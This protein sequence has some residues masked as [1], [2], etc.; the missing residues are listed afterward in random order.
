MFQGY[1]TIYYLLSGLVDMKTSSSLQE[2]EPGR[3]QRSQQEPEPGRHQRS[4]PPRRLSMEQ[5]R[6]TPRRLSTE[7]FSGSALCP[8]TVCRRSRKGVNVRKDI[9][10]LSCHTEKDKYGEIFYFIFFNPHQSDQ[11]QKGPCCFQRLNALK[12]LKCQ[13]IQKIPNPFLGSYLFN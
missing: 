9:K 4:Q 12:C 8:P 11:G 13:R 10:K 7:A 3:H 5:Q 1:R 6:S 2:H